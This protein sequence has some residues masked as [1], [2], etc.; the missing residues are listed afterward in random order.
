[1]DMSF[2][3]TKQRSQLVTLTVESGEAVYVLHPN[4]IAAFQGEPSNREDSLMKLPGMYRKKRL[5]QSRIRGPAQVLLGLPDSYCVTPVE[6]AKDDDLLFEYRHVLFYNEGLTYKTHIQRIRHAL[7]TRDLVKMRFAGPGTLGL[8]TAGPLYP[9]EL[10]PDKPLYV[11]MGCLVAYPR[12]VSIKP[13]VYG[14]TLASQTMKYQWELAGRGTVLL[15]P[16]RPDPALDEQLQGDSLVRRVLR[17]LLPF[18]GV[19]IK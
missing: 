13:C 4:Q 3:H 18:G 1:M 9:V 19:F 7:L 12:E 6:I 2:E 16:S 5:I 17:E 11:E 15:Q 8:I 10:K 14:N